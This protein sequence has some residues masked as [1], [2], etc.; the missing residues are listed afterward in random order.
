MKKDSLF[1]ELVSEFLGTM[2]LILFGDGVVA[3]V[4]LFGTGVPGEVVNGGFTNI[5][6]G[7]GLAVMLG[8]YTARRS[9]A[10]INPAVTLAFAVSRDF[11]WRKVIPYSLAQVAGAFVAAA[12]IFLNYHP[13]F[14]KVDPNLETTASVFATFP[15]FP[16]APMAGFIDQVLGT[17]LL[18]FL[19]LAI[20]EHAPDSLQPALIGSVVLAIG[21]SF[22]AMHGYAI[23]PARDFGPRLFIVLA[24]F[25]NNGL[26]DG[27][28][29]FWVPIAG[30]LLGGV[31]GGLL[32]DACVR[33]Y[34]P[35]ATTGATLAER[36][37]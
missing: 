18:V 12:L 32:F 36:D 14:M 15:A 3:M 21:I 27:T 19:I 29:I 20:V 1:G 17:A 5:T 28:N 11:P 34:L 8:V 30:P 7:W 23:N 6:L 22:G 9:G 24:G 13:A 4:K 25:K 10:H 35:K 31:A 16:E 2:V 37:H 26:T 33:R